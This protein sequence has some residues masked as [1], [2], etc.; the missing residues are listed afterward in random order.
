M[1]QPISCERPPENYETLYRLLVHDLAEYA[2]FLIDG[3]GCI[4]SWNK[5]VEQLAADMDSSS[6]APARPSGPF[7]PFI[8]SI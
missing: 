2:V 3:D 6:C 1:N 7:H 4:V 8:S 5:G